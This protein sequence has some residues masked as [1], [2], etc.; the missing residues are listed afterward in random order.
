MDL[1]QRFQD[2]LKRSGTADHLRRLQQL[3]EP[4]V[5]QI[6]PLLQL[7]LRP[8]FSPADFKRAE[9]GQQRI[10]RV[11]KGIIEHV[12]NQASQ[13]VL[14]AVQHVLGRDPLHTHDD[15]VQRAHF[16]TMVN[17]SALTRDVHLQLTRLRE[18]S[19]LHIQ[20]QSTQEQ[21]R[22]FNAVRVTLNGF[23]NHQENIQRQFQQ[24]QTTMQEQFQQVQNR[25]EHQG[26]QITQEQREGL[27][28]VLQRV[29]AA[30]DATVDRLVE[31]QVGVDSI[32]HHVNALN[33]FLAEERA[34]E[35]R[36]RRQEEEQ[37]ATRQRLNDV[38]TACGF[39]SALGTR[40]GSR[41]LQRVGAVGQHLVAGYA[42]CQSLAPIMAG[43][44]GA[45][46]ALG[47]FCALA[48]AAMGILAVFDN[49]QG[50][51]AMAEMIQMLSEQVEA[52]RIEMHERFDQ[53]FRQLYI[54]FRAVH[55]QLRLIHLSLTT[56]NGQMVQIDGRIQGLVDII[57]R[58]SDDRVWN[59]L[60]A[61]LSGARD[62]M[63]NPGTFW[64]QPSDQYQRIASEL[65]S[66][67]S[68]IPR[69]ESGFGLLAE[70]DDEAQS[71]TGALQLIA[72]VENQIEAFPG[73][74][75][76]CL[77]LC[78]CSVTTP[79]APNAWLWTAAAGSYRDWRKMQLSNESFCFGH[80]PRRQ[81][82]GIIETGA[83][84]IEFCWILLDPA[85]G[86]NVR[87][88][89]REAYA[90]AM[91]DVSDL[92]GAV[93]AEQNQILAQAT[94]LPLTVE[95]TVQDA[96]DY[97]VGLPQNAVPQVNFHF[98]PKAP[99]GEGPD[100]NRFAYPS[101]AQCLNHAIAVQQGRDNVF[102]PL[103]HAA[104]VMQLG[105][106]QAQVGA[107]LTDGKKQWWLA[108]GNT[109]MMLEFRAQA[110]QDEV[111]VQVMSATA[112]GEQ[113]HWGKNQSSVDALLAF[114]ARPQ[115]MA[116][117]TQPPAVGAM[118]CIQGLVEG[119]IL[120]AKQQ[121]LAALLNL[122]ADP[123]V[124]RAKLLVKTMKAVDRCIAG[125]R[126]EN[127]P[128]IVST[129]FESVQRQHGQA[130]LGPLPQLGETNLPADAGGPSPTVHRVRHEIEQLRQV[131]RELNLLPS[132]ED[133]TSTD[134]QD[135]EILTANPELQELYIHRACW[136]RAPR[137]LGTNENS[138]TFV[139]EGRLIWRN[140]GN[141]VVPVA[142]KTVPANLVDAAMT[143]VDKI[144]RKQRQGQLSAILYVFGWTRHCN[145]VNPGLQPSCTLILEL[146]E[147]NLNAYL[148]ATWEE[149]RPISEAMMNRFGRQ[150]VKG[151]GQLH[152]AGIIHRDIKDSNCI[153]V[154]SQ[155]GLALKLADCGIAIATE[156][157]TATQTNRGQNPLGTELW[158]PLRILW[159]G[160][161]HDHR[162]DWWA[163]GLVLLC[164]VYGRCIFGN[165]RLV[166]DRWD[167][168]RKLLE[169]SQLQGVVGNV[170][171]PR[172][173]SEAYW[174]EAAVRSC[175][176]EE[177]PRVPRQ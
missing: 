116:D 89:L 49:N 41:G 125:T 37:Q 102:P 63:D 175:L 55:D 88:R 31:L 25:L 78:G 90:A 155:N 28:Q 71:L 29:G 131:Q 47:P 83:R 11:Q 27:Q 4:D 68:F 138:G 134:K 52:L 167:L 74:I 162:S 174:I 98:R 126:E 2:E 140:I 22:Q 85:P 38:S 26:A 127:Y 132:E 12:R 43:Q 168:R 118:Q 165:D 86:R 105:T 80:C 76:A 10:Q 77:S 5:D 169:S 153:L 9:Q 84:Y 141:K 123:A 100:G 154:R 54:E 97:V 146:G 106:W 64:Q 136:Y 44:L 69:S 51:D 133:D 159:A 113:Q 7:I 124:L 120:A 177:A 75:A 104:W 13:G 66:R 36:A 115:D 135:A 48:G 67:C 137:L 73:I 70:G 16:L 172:E 42:A 59:D 6:A 34:V 62:V 20:N 40:V 173:G 18:D 60:E 139:S 121:T 15:A 17:T 160:E 81:L 21:Q 158:L 95:S 164:M 150:L 171:F 156:T 129:F 144:G 87:F 1:Y 30:E 103:L 170:T 130:Q 161:D 58:L 57:L 163:T 94:N 122:A 147:C 166:E 152:D 79:Q 56:V 149:G 45:M 24:G 96:I 91:Q 109:G 14:Q 151:V 114:I 143:E 101:A 32:L 128:C 82:Q 112:A 107:N 72:A 145:M 35:A 39:L 142:L 50:S 61:K 148:E 99:G 46:A 33:N 93:M 65:A 108:G 3:Q 92:V 53:L 110:G 119:R 157:V 176:R 117:L 111:A 23:L 8:R 19:V